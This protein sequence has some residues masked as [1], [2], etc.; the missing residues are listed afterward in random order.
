MTYTI[1]TA[2]LVLALI[3]VVIAVVFMTEEE[4]PRETFEISLH[5]SPVLPDAGHVGQPVSATLNEPE[6]KESREIRVVDVPEAI[7]RDTGPVGL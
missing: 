3:A 4:E 7:Y 6:E 2:L 5:Q 1:V